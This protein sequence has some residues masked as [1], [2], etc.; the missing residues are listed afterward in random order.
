MVKFTC[1]KY[2]DS[3]ACVIST[4]S[5]PRRNLDLG[6]KVMVVLWS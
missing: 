1:L 4:S 2:L 5:I 3:M 6:I